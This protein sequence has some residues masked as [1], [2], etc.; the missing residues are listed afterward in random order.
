MSL[1]PFLSP[2]WVDDVTRLIQNFKISTERFRKWI[3][4]WEIPFTFDFHLSINI[5]AWNSGLDLYD[6]FLG[7]WRHHR[8]LKLYNFEIV[9]SKTITSPQIFRY[10]WLPS[11]YHHW[12]M[13]Y[14]FGYFLTQFWVNDVTT[15]VKIAIFWESDLRSKLRTLKFCQILILI[16]LSDSIDDIHPWALFAQF[17][18]NDV[19]KEINIPEFWKI[20]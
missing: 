2:F 4:H 1:G 6:L 19:T 17:G 9:V 11:F 7:W 13:T 15:V 5:S 14:K 18:D 8:E 16:F 20:K 3:I 12:Y 10:Y